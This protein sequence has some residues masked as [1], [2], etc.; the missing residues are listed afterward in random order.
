MRQAWA[1]TIPYDCDVQIGFD[2]RVAG[3]TGV[4]L[5]HIPFDPFLPLVGYPQPARQPYYPSGGFTRPDGVPPTWVYLLD[6]VQLTWRA[7]R[8]FEE[9]SQDQ[10]LA[11]LPRNRSPWVRPSWPEATLD[12]APLGAYRVTLDNTSQYI[13]LSDPDNPRAR[14]TMLGPYRAKFAFD[15]VHAPPGPYAIGAR[16]NTVRGVL[17]DEWSEAQMAL[18]HRYRLRVRRW[19]DPLNLERV[20]LF[21][22]VGATRAELDQGG[23]TLHDRSID[24]GALYP[25]TQNPAADNV[26]R[27]LGL[28][29]LDLPV[30]GGWRQVDVRIVGVAEQVSL[31]ATSLGMSTPEWQEL[32][33]QSTVYLAGL[34]WSVNGVVMH[35]DPCD[36]G[37]L[38]GSGGPLVSYEEDAAGAWVIRNRY[39]ELATVGERLHRGRGTAWARGDSLVAGPPSESGGCNRIALRPPEESATRG[40]VVVHDG[41]G[42]ELR[43]FGAPLLYPR[44]AAAEQPAGGWDTDE[45]RRVMAAQGA[46]SAF[47]Q[48]AQADGAALKALAWDGDPARLPVDAPWPV[49][50]TGPLW[51]GRY[52]PDGRRIDL[53]WPQHPEHSAT[54]IL[55]DG[56]RL[57]IPRSYPLPIL[58]SPA[59]EYSLKQEAS[60]GKWPVVLRPAHALQTASDPWDS[61][62]AYTPAAAVD[63]PALAPQRMHAWDARVVIDPLSREAHLV[64]LAEVWGER[65]T[66]AENPD[67]AV[68]DVALRAQAVPLD[69]GRASEPATLATL[70]ALLP[71]WRAYALADA[72]VLPSGRWVVAVWRLHWTGAHDLLWYLG[73]PAGLALGYSHLDIGRPVGRELRLAAD[74]VSAELTAWWLARADGELALWRLVA[75]VVPGAQPQP[76]KAQ[77]VAEPDPPYGAWASGAPLPRRLGGLEVTDAGWHRLRVVTAG[78]IDPLPTLGLLPG[79]PR[80][81]WADLDEQRVPDLQ[82]WEAQGDPLGDSPYAAAPVDHLPAR[83]DS[84]W[85]YGAELSWP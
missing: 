27:G 34:W 38:E 15:N 17:E 60:G 24:W 74:P 78:W 5:P 58:W 55:A 23:E 32:Q 48:F 6:K 85:W 20:E 70:P 49:V 44:Y 72:A 56:K 50:G 28:Y 57:P 66:A 25:D 40:R 67:Y 52:L 46:F 82:Q 81:L 59:E 33:G 43:N 69:T 12:G 45:D 71:P 51:L 8:L 19:A 63:P 3:M 7:G 22:N 21:H 4:W 37:V 26:Y 2:I 53:A 47:D 79:D 13:D 29:P 36:D 16:R 68:P 14:W 76:A 9:L 31:S 35:A 30:G 73:G 83:M 1:G 18:W 39:A 54:D 62:D 77:V 84:R 65:W 64:G 75:P 10:D 80:P 61:F 42:T 11:G 41:A